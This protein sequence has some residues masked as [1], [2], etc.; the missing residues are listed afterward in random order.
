MS[1]ARDVLIW[2]GWAALFLA[3]VSERMSMGYLM[4]ILGRLL[5]TIMLSEPVGSAYLCGWRALYMISV[6][7]ECVFRCCTF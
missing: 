2:R 1:V 7:W 5:G 3:L 4:I 6:S